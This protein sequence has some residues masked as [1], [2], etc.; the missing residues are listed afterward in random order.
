MMTGDSIV[1]DCQSVIRVQFKLGA[2][3]PPNLLKLS[4]A[5]VPQPG[6]FVVVVTDV[7]VVVG[8]GMVD[9]LV[10]EGGPKPLNS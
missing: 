5:G 3:S 6:G 7:D 8:T 4:D 2:T 10:V 9:V 1:K